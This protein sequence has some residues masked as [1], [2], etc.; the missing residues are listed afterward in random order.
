MVRNASAVMQ[1]EMPIWAC[2]CDTGARNTN[3]VCDAVRYTTMMREAKNNG[4]TN[5]QC[6]RSLLCSVKV[7][8]SWEQL[9][10]MG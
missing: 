2:Q 4:L 10:L 7:E 8:T 3:V 9:G 5:A 1:L 6:F